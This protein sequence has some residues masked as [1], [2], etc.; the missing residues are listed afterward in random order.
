MKRLRLVFMSVMIALFVGVPVYAEITSDTVSVVINNQWVKNQIINDAYFDLYSSEGEYLGTQSCEVITN[1][2]SILTFNVP[3]YSSGKEFVLHMNYGYSV[4]QYYNDIITDGGSFTLGTY[5]YSDENGQSVINNTFYLTGVPYSAGKMNFLAGYR[6]IDMDLKLYKGIPSAPADL[7]LDSLGI[8]YLWNTYSMT[9]G[10]NGTELTVTPD[11][12]TAYV[13]GYPVDMGVNMT[14][15]DGKFYIPVGFVTSVFGIPVT[16]DEYNGNTNMN[17]V[18]PK[19]GFESGKTTVSENIPSENT[20]NTAEAPLASN[21]AEDYVNSAG[22]SSKTDYLIWIS[23]KDY[24]L[25]VFLGS[26]GNWKLCKTFDCTIGKASSPTITGQFEY[27]SKESKWTYDNFYVGP[28]MRFKG[29]YAIHSTLLSYS[30]GDYDARVGMQ[31]SHG[32]VRVRK[33]NIDWLV[34]YVPLYTKIYITE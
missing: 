28:I 25:Y 10:Y 32:C 23:K 21:S 2:N 1:T 27:F 16:V 17:A 13:N 5:S 18:L 15:A 11:S 30:G 29:G 33:P 20:Q 8:P 19:T 22:I 14:Y 26:A 4:L 34:S 7:M 24:K 6:L 3:Q 31:L 9:A 12:S